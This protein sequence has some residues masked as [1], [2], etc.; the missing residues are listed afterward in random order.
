MLYRIVVEE[1][2]TP[3]W[4]QTYYTLASSFTAAEEKVTKR[5]KKDFAKTPF[6]VVSIQI[7][8]AKFVK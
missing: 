2:G 4:S 1:K 5:A 8:D 7:A 6:R 3:A